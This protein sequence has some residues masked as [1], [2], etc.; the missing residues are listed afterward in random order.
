MTRIMQ[1]DVGE[2]GF[3]LTS[4]Q[5]Q[6]S[7][8]PPANRPRKQIL[9]AIGFQSEKYVSDSLRQIVGNSH[10]R[11]FIR[12]RGTSALVSSTAAPSRPLR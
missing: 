4:F 9:A 7:R 3:R 2:S 8:I 12:Q 1:P 6:Y 11:R 10:C 5:I